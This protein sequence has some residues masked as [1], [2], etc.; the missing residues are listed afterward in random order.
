MVDIAEAAQLSGLAPDQ[1]RDFEALGVIPRARRGASGRRF[2]G[3]EEVRRLRL[4]RR[5]RD[6]GIPVQDIKQLLWGQT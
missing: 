4:I 6:L 5:V 1:I 3:I 2:F